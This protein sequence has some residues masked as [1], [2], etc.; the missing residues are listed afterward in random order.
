MSH[1]VVFRKRIDGGFLHDDVYLKRVMSLPFCPPLG[2]LVIDGNWEAMVTELVWDE[3][4]KYIEAWTHADN[5]LMKELDADKSPL[6]IAEEYTGWK[7][8]I[9]E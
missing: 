6:E 5:T 2:M 3:D 8:E 1:M 9:D 4:E 7:V